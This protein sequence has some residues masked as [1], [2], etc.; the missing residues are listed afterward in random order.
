MHFLEFQQ[1]K[2]CPKSEMY[3]GSMEG[4]MIHA[5]WVG[6]EFNPGEEINSESK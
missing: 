6:Y 2:S 3:I 4:H 1:V 5:T